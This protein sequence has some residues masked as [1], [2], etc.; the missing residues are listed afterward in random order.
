MQQHTLPLFLGGLEKEIVIIPFGGF[1]HRLVML[2]PQHRHRVIRNRL[3]MFPQISL[4]L[5]K[6]GLGDVIAS[7]GSTGTDPGGWPHAA[8]ATSARRP[9]TVIATLSTRT[10]PHPL[11]QRVH[12]PD[13]P[14]YLPQHE[15][16]QRPTTTLVMTI[17]VIVAVE[18]VGL[19]RRRRV[20]V[21]RL[22]RDEGEQ[23]E[24]LLVVG[25]ACAFEDRGGLLQG[26]G[27]QV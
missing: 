17:I 3:E 10:L 24:K 6:T 20:P 16:R 4:Q 27:V 14:V 25:R 1:F 9:G 26:C 2:P 11:R 13:D 18:F 23:E 19:L 7:T 8:S 12:D 22:Q 21:H 5:R 15:L